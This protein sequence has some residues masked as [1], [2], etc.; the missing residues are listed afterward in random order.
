[1][2]NRRGIDE[3][4]GELPTHARTSEIVGCLP[5]GDYANGLTGRRTSEDQTRDHAA[6]LS[7]ISEA[8]FGA[9]D[10]P[11]PAG[12]S[13]QAGT[14]PR[15]GEARYEA[16][17]HGDRG[18]LYVTEGGD[19][20]ADVCG[21]E[22]ADLLVDALR[23]RSEAASPCEDC[24][25]VVRNGTLMHE[26]SCRWVTSG[27][28]R[29]AEAR[30]ECRWKL[31][32]R[33]RVGTDPDAVWVCKAINGERTE[34]LLEHQA[35]DWAGW[36]SVNDVGLS[37]E[38]PKTSVRNDTKG[39]ESC[40][41][42][43]VA[44]QATTPSPAGSSLRTAAGSSSSDTTEGTTTS[45]SATPSR[46]PASDVPGPAVA[47]A[48]GPNASLAHKVG[49]RI[50]LGSG[51]LVELRGKHGT[52]VD[53]RNDRVPEVQVEI[54]ANRMWF[55]GYDCNKST[56]TPSKA[57]SC[58]CWP[59]H[60]PFCHIGGMVESRSDGGDLSLL[61]D[62]AKPAASNPGDRR[63]VRD[64]REDVLVQ[65]ADVR[66]SRRPGD[67]GRG[68]V[69]GGSTHRGR[70]ED[71]R[72]VLETTPSSSEARHITSQAELIMRYE[73]ELSALRRV[74]SIAR[75]ILPLLP[76][77]DGCG[78]LVAGANDPDVRVHADQLHVAFDA[79]H[80]TAPKGGDPR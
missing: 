36:F 11:P 56:P 77:T 67:G 79:L 38:G 48:A 8:A 13:R 1:M 62:E 4:Q 57:E 16:K 73:A 27:Y 40:E 41:S 66:A 30:P 63:S 23:R 80:K 45:A 37:R 55:Y 50:V 24:R 69:E 44:T 9:S 31:G 52:V 15:S 10:H 19:L 32:D 75:K 26:T 7:P 70:S 61:R 18:W 49:D 3:P 72:E 68:S 43:P 64:G 42:S 6:G 25:A 20:L 53:V 22:I 5:I 29:T 28:L 2:T 21:Q 12:V 78:N 65:A 17:P 51:V 74:V 60:E 46:A 39:T 33:V 59:S 76:Y 47:L 34:M 35:K 58:G 14:T 54:G 71:G